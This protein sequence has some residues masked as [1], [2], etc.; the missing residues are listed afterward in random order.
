MCWI[1]VGPANRL[2]IFV[3]SL[4]VA[5][6]LACQV[7]ERGEDAPREQVTFDFV[8]PEFHL[9]EPGRVGGREVQ[10][11]PR[12]SVEER[13][14][15]LR[16]VSGQV[17]DDDVDLAAG[18]GRHHVAQELHE[19]RAGVPGH[20]LADDLAGPRVQCGVQRQGAMPVAVFSSTA[21]TTA[22]SGGFRYRPITSAAFCSNAGSSDSM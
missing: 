16:L 7:G 17:V 11:D 13:L 12:V 21:T 2:R 4:D 14:H 9:V 3:V 5:A 22:W 18:V 19:R 10:L 6:D 20:R 8:E 1:A 15:Q